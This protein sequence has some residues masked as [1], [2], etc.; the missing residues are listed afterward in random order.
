[1]LALVSLRLLDPFPRINARFDNISLANTVVVVLSLSRVQL[2]A[3]P[4]TAERQTSLSFTISRVHE[5]L[6][7][8]S[9]WC[10]PTI[11]S[12]A[13]PF[14]ICLQSFPASGSFP[15]CYL[16]ASGGQSIGA[17][18]SV[19]PISIQGWFLLGLTGLISLLSKGTFKSLLQHQSFKASILR[20]SAFLM[21]Q[22][23]HLY[24]TTGKTI[25]LTVWPTLSWPSEKFTKTF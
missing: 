15:M 8:L 2:F 5:N 4:W 6:C 17:S 3:T 20:F 19:L 16:F 25:P 7:P 22:H 24:V 23:S 11:S 10:D 12:S 9:Q 21:I 1:M 14:S 13:T 18:A